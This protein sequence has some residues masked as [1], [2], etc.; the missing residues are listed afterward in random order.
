MVGND[1]FHVAPGLWPAP[2][3]VWRVVLGREV[4][5][6]LASTPCPFAPMA[7][8]FLDHTS[9]ADWHPEAV[10]GV[11]SGGRDSGEE[12]LAEHLSVK[13]GLLP[14]AEKTFLLTPQSSHL[15]GDRDYSLHL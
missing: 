8:S 5:A 14:T 2:L 12:L 7:G 10:V 13:S 6:Q 15:F 9:Q 1:R 4:L 11:G 3:F